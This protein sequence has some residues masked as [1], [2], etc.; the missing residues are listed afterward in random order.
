MTNGLESVVHNGP[1]T[2]GIDTL[3]RSA[4]KIPESFLRG[5]GVPEAQII[6]LPSILGA[7]QPIQFY[8]CFISYSTKET[9]FAER[10]H[11][12]LQGKGLRCWYAPEDLKIGEEFRV[13]I[14]ESIRLHDKLLLILSENSIRSPWVKKE[15]ESAMEHEHEQGRLILFPI[16]LDDAVNS[17]KLGWPADVR[18]SRHIGDFTGWKDHDSYTKAFERLLR[19]LQAEAAKDTTR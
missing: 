8:S 13:R 16:R 10:L 6:Y 5:C 4:G 1:S 17:I 15:V 9:E 2:I 3:F 12:D 11:N 19:D 7:M 14:D 18:R